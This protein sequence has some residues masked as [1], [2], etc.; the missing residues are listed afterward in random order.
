MS[1]D[2][3]VAGNGHLGGGLGPAVAAAPVPGPAAAPAEKSSWPNSSGGGMPK[4]PSGPLVS[5]SQLRITT[6]TIEPMPRVA[7][8]T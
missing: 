3:R 2:E 7:I 5:A 6:T 4:M 8:A 1:V